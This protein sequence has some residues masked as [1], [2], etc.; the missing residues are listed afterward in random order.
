[1]P[2]PLRMQ[3]QLATC[4]AL[5]ALILCIV[6]S[7]T[8]ARDSC[9]H[10]GC[11]FSEKD[12]LLNS[13]EF[14]ESRVVRALAGAKL[15][16]N[17]TLLACAPPGRT[18]DMSI[19]V[20]TH[21]QLQLLKELD[22]AKVNKTNAPFLEPDVNFFTHI[23]QA[24]NFTIYFQ[25]HGGDYVIAF[26]LNPAA[27]NQSV[28]VQ[29]QYDAVF[30]YDVCH[31][32]VGGVFGVFLCVVSVFACILIVT[33][34][35]R[36][37]V[38]I[39]AQNALEQLTERHERQLSKY[40]EEKRLRE[41]KERA[42][43]FNA[44]FVPGCYRRCQCCGI[45][46][47]PKYPFFPHHWLF[48]HDWLSFIRPAPDERLNR[49]NK[50]L[51]ILTKVI[52]G[53][54][55][56]TLWI[57]PIIPASSVISSTSL[58]AAWKEILAEMFTKS[59]VIWV[60]AELIGIFYPWLLLK[61]QNKGNQRNEITIGGTTYEVEDPA[62]RTPKWRSTLNLVL[63]ELGAFVLLVMVFLLML[64]I[65]R[66]RD[67]LS[68][69]YVDSIVIQIFVLE[70]Y[71]LI[72]PGILAS[73]VVYM[74]RNTWGVPPPAP[75]VPIEDADAHAYAKAETEDHELTNSLNTEAGDTREFSF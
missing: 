67:Y 54:I 74:V 70:F 19:M 44:P 2:R 35:F 68:C 60:V 47:Q 7:P 26:Y 29:F 41:R 65:Y 34:N 1:V 45:M 8:R 43:W 4:V 39:K 25:K 3:Q 69:R 52:A 59:F 63:R 20:V 50:L 58:P 16:V 72:F 57:M 37:E 18:C 56:L 53:I 42:T 31:G 33:S 5:V 6:V 75:D 30:D 40:Q 46:T 24:R 51:V 10:D 32:Y 22:M 27:H 64:S 55:L 36:R 17:T 66:V 12:V 71:R 28:S 21:D 9:L 38:A 61:A 48:T 62:R 15:F 73:W 11:S 23:T 14:H 49:W 13:W